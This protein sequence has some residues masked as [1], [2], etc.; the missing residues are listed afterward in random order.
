M[1]EDRLKGPKKFGVIFKLDLN[2]ILSVWPSLLSVQN[3]A[4]SQIFKNVMKAMDPF[5][6]HIY[7]HQVE[8]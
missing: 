6:K 2:W 5:L 4:T 8:H 7:A 1:W 3:F